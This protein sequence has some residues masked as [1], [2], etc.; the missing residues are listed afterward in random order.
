MHRARRAGLSALIVLVI[1]LIGLVPARQPRPRRRAA[2][3]RC[4]LASVD[5][6][7]LRG[8]DR[9]H[10]RVRRV[11]RGGEPGRCAGRPR[12]A[13]ARLRD[14]DRRNDHPQGDVDVADA[15]RAGPAR[16]RRQQHGDLRGDRRLLIQR[17][18]GGDRWRDGAAGRGWHADRRGR[19]GRRGEPLCRGDGRRRAICRFEPRTTARRWRRQRHRH[20]R[21]RERFLRPGGALAAER[22]GAAGARAGYQPDSHADARAEPDTCADA[23]AT[24]TRRPTPTPQPTPAP[25]HAHADPDAAPIPTPTP[26]PPPDPTPTPAPTPTPIRRR[27]R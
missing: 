10:V 5:A 1:L 7:R 8:P 27:P 2:G 15:P 20:E 23:D 21:Q 26:T 14:L 22:G 16:A 4:Q 6:G 24:P 11:R 25:T 17:R 13:G 3:R 12:R 9:R 19:V 18:P